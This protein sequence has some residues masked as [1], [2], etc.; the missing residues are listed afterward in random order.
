MHSS[1]VR[2]RRGVFLGKSSPF[3]LHVA[4]GQCVCSAKGGVREG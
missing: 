1:Q 3:S 4:H 2:L